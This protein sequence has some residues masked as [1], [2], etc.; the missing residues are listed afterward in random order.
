MPRKDR[1][2]RFGRLELDSRALFHTFPIGLSALVTGR[3]APLQCGLAPPRPTS[4]A[5]MTRP[6]VSLETRPHVQI[7]AEQTS[8]Q[9]ARTEPVSIPMNVD[10]TMSVSL[11]YFFLLILPRLFMYFARFKISA[12]ENT[13]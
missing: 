1:I 7:F 6:A 8:T 11:S 12:V 5:R 2:K 3:G 4:L 10:F 13:R 9:R